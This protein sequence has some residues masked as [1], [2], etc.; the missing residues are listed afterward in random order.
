MD[1]VL[2]PIPDISGQLD[3]LDAIA[4]ATTTAPNPAVD[5]M[6]GTVGVLW[7]VPELHGQMVLA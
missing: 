7:D 6:P 2:F 3:L 4:D 1:L 5:V